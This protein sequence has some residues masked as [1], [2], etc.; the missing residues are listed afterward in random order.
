V[1]PIEP[2]NI[3]EKK[4]RTRSKKSSVDSQ[5][6]E[7]SNSTSIQL[8]TSTN[9]NNVEMISFV[10]KSNEE[11]EKDIEKIGGELHLSSVDSSNDKSESIIK[12]IPLS[13]EQQR[14]K[15]EQQNSAIDIPNTD[16]K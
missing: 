13:D 4:S 16:I 9:D 14:L 7:I 8:D 15:S 6:N 11:K 10:S 3:P 1:I 12:E 2:I 5:S